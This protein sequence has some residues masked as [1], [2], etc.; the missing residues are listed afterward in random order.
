MPTRRTR[1]PTAGSRDT[2]PHRR[3]RRLT[4]NVT[5]S[6]GQ[7]GGSRLVRW[8]HDA[9]CQVVVRNHTLSAATNGDYEQTW[10]ELR[11]LG[12]DRA[13]RKYLVYAD[14]NA[15]YCGIGEVYPDDRP[16][17]TNTNNVGNM[18]ALV[19]Q[20]CWDETAGG[21]GTHELFHNMGAVQ[22]SSP[23]S[24]G[25]GHCFDG[26]IGGADIM[27]YAENG[28]AA[29]D[30]C[31]VGGPKQL[32][33]GKDDYF[34]TSP[35]P[36]TYLATHLEYCG[37]RVPRRRRYVVRPIQRRVRLT[38]PGRSDLVLSGGIDWVQRQRHPGAR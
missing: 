6:A 13:D 9:G 11:A 7:T 16:E 15:D 35:P 33:C 5:F 27:C 10:S 25:A 38:D 2:K 37:Q 34:H 8:V 19:T 20:G 22:D 36:G 31:A 14:W 3:R 1:P 29:Y 4:A 12:Y 28:Q 24:T 32:D 21:T 26:T 18:Y 30:R 17:A 23:N